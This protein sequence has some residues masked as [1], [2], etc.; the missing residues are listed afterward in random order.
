MPR[1]FL[2]K[3]SVLGR[4]SLNHIQ[5]VCSKLWFQCCNC[6]CLL[7]APNQPLKSMYDM[8]VW[9]AQV[10]RMLWKRAKLLKTRKTR[11]GQVKEEPWSQCQRIQNRIAQFD[12][13]LVCACG[14]WPVS[15][16]YSS[17]PPYFMIF[18]VFGILLRFS[19]VGFDQA[20]CHLW[21]NRIKTCVP[22]MQIPT[23]RTRQ[24]CMNVVLQTQ[25][26]KPPNW[27]YQWSCP[28]LARQW[29]YPPAIKR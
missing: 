8:L 10:A 7:L 13:V 27:V 25:C 12:Y 9:D 21:P 22:K 18:R 17:K 16:P 19:F 2:S 28:F 11:E 26:H 1:R 3:K 14:L 29:T 15:R 24:R 4:S 23:K 20:G 6:W 5:V